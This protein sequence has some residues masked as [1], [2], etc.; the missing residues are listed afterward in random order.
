M[1]AGEVA[2]V[3]RVEA[4]TVVKWLSDGHLPGFQIGP[5]RAWRL[6]RDEIREYLE[7]NRN[8][9]SRAGI[10]PFA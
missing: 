10:S 2:E 8:T 6:W 7:A 1:T 3:F 4:A 5:K 9:G